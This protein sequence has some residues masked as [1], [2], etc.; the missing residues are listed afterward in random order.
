MANDHMGINANSRGERLRALT[1]DPDTFLPIFQ[2]ILQNYA[3][4]HSTFAQ[5]YTETLNQAM[6][7]SSYAKVELIFDR[8]GFGVARFKRLTY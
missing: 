4:N 6:G 5:T 8:S 3:G 7:Q 1:A 2:E